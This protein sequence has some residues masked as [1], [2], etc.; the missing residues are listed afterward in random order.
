MI[1]GREPRGG[2]R[3]LSRVRPLR[4]LLVAVLAVGVGACGADEVDPVMTPGDD[5]S[6]FGRT[7]IS[8]QVLIDDDDHELASDAPIVLE[9]VDGEVRAS[10]GCNTLYG[11]VESLHGGILV[12]S[13]LGGTERGCPRD[14]HEQD[15]WLTEFLSS[16]PR[17]TLDR[18]VLVLASSSVEIEL[19]DRRVADPDRPLEGTRW[20]IDS[21]I[22]GDGP[23]GSVAQFPAADAHLHFEDG[24]VTGFTGCNQVHGTYEIDGSRITVG[25]L[26][27][28]DVACPARL[29][30]GEAAVGAIS[31]QELTT[32]VVAR[33]LTLIGD[34]GT[35]LGLRADD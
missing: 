29:A 18:E 8:Q 5:A 2:A 31:G 25:E 6:P 10:A 3:R 9:F 7:F 28:T 20:Q 24:T 15:E 11:T 35:G 27:Q 12:L 23:D 22:E 17:W 13:P 32:D 26:V 30:H 19:L 16:R 1:P 33:R 14:L 34:D 21:I 4:T